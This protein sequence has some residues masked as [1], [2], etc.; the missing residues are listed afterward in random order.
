MKKKLFVMV[1]FAAA[2]ASAQGV[3][4]GVTG[5]AGAFGD[6]GRNSSGGEV[7]AE[8]C[9]FCSGTYALFGEYTHWFSGSSRTVNLGGGGIRIQGRSRVRPFIDIGAVGGEDQH[10]GI[11]AIVLGTGVRIPLS[12]HWYVRPQF[13]FYGSIHAAAIGSVGIGYRF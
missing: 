11:G 8:A 5:G 13:R 7:G 9:L 4:L 2:I 12:E 1:F 3:E 10:A 6:F